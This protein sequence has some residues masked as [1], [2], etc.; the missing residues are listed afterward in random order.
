MSGIDYG[1][2]SET[3]YHVT[4]R[5]ERGFYFLSV[6]SGVAVEEQRLSEVLEMPTVEAKDPMAGDQ[7]PPLDLLG[8]LGDEVERWPRLAVKENMW[9]NQFN[10]FLLISCNSKQ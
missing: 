2:V 3:G 10:V 4:L 5:L 9:T 1:G 7:D 8:T 6:I